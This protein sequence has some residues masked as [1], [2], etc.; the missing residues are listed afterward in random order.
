[1]TRTTMETNREIQIW[2]MG[3]G[4][5]F[6]AVEVLLLVGMCL[7][8]GCKK[9][10]PEVEAVRRIEQEIEAKIAEIPNA[11]VRATGAYE[12][13]RSIRMNIS[14][15]PDVEQQFKWYRKAVDTVFNTEIGH[16]SLYDQGRSISAFWEL[17]GAICI[18]GNGNYEDIWRNRLDDMAWRQKQIDRLKKEYAKVKPQSWAKPIPASAFRR[19]RGVKGLI[20]STKCSLDAQITRYERYFWDDEYLMSA[21]CR[22]NVQQKFEAFLGRPIRT[23]KQIDEDLE[24]R[25]DAFRQAEEAAM[26]KTNRPPP[27]ILIDGTK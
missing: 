8:F 25:T 24:K 16:L 10:N 18:K 1:M 3:A 13:G 15:L 4:G 27:L 23:L 12:F 7:S 14:E 2:R 5:F 9:K 17:W 21:E 11:L 6:F 20:N 19:I 22:T 26:S